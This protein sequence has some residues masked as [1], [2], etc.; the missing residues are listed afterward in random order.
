M[1]SVESKYH[2]YT[3]FSLHNS[4]WIANWFYGEL[5][6]LR[7]EMENSL[8]VP[9]SNDVVFKFLQDCL[10]ITFNPRQY[11]RDNPEKLTVPFNKDTEDRIIYDTV[12]RVQHVAC[13]ILSLL[14]DN[15]DSN[16]ANATFL[17]SVS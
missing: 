1:L 11:F 16:L 3:L 7:K 5:P 2:Q 13:K 14:Y 15:Y 8:E 10:L 9:V 4:N 17:L 12:Q 6:C